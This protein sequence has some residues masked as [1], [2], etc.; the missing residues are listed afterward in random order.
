[1][2]LGK[3][4]PTSQFASATLYRSEQAKKPEKGRKSETGIAIANCNCNVQFILYN[5]K[6]VIA[7]CNL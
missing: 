7:I 6:I 1:M 4:L 3:V 5:L 2:I